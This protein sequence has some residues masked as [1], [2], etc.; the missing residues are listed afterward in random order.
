MNVRADAAHRRGRP[1]SS[2]PPAVP[3]SKL[4]MPAGLLL[5]SSIW[6]LEREQRRPGEPVSSSAR[7]CPPRC[8]SA[9]GWLGPYRLLAAVTTGLTEIGTFAATTPASPSEIQRAFVQ[10]CTMWSTAAPTP[11][12]R[13]F[14]LC[15]PL[16]PAGHRGVADAG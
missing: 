14:S 1:P 11:E 2:S 7:T 6:I 16:L 4:P 3:L 10:A 15:S 12:G 9:D 8:Y 5:L 13:R